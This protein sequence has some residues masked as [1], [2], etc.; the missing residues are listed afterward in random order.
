LSTQDVAV[1]IVVFEQLCESY[2]GTA[3]ESSDMK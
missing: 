2:G 1:G 3:M